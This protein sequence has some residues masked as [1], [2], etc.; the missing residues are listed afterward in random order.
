M[1]KVSKFKFGIPQAKSGLEQSRKP[2]TAE[3]ME[4]FLHTIAPVMKVL[5]I[6]PTG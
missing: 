6:F 3:L 4:S 2:T 5:K 1:V